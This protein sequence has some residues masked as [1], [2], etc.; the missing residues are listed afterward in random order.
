MGIQYIV[1]CHRRAMSFVNVNH[2]YSHGGSIDIHYTRTTEHL[3]MS[4]SSFLLHVANTQESIFP[5]Q[6][7][8]SLGT[9]GTGAELFSWNKGRANLALLVSWCI[10]IPNRLWD[11][12][13]CVNSCMSVRTC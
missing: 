13:P 8:V 4:K 1:G 11:N 7:P 10:S 6:A 5:N 2:L 3:G 12:D 9:F